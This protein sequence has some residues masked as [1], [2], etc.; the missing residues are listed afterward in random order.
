MER[1]DIQAEQWLEL[2]VQKNDMN[3]KLILSRVLLHSIEE[4]RSERAL[5]LVHDVAR[6]NVPEALFQLGQMSEYGLG[7]EASFTLAEQSYT[8]AAEED[9]STGLLQS[10]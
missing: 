5:Q 4:K 1:D 9:Y 7:G 8:R 6:E 10:H 2:A 3:A